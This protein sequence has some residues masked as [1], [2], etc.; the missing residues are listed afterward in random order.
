MP[1]LDFPNPLLI[2]VGP[3]A[4]GKTVFAV[5]IA[6]RL[7]GEIV[8]ADSR[9]F[10]RGMNIGTDK[11]LPE[12]RQSIPHH[13]IDIANP[14]E[15]WDLVRFQ[16]ASCQTI[17]AIENRGHLPILVGGTGQYVHAVI[18][19][20][21]A[22][23]Q[24]PNYTLRKAIEKWGQEIGAEQLHRRLGLLDV[25]SARIIEPHNLRRTVRALEVIFTTGRRFSDQR[26]KKDSPYSLCIL[27]LKRD[28]KELFQRIDARIDQMVENGLLDEVKGLLERGFSA[29]LP[30]LSAI[31]YR[32]MASVIEGRMTLEEAVTQMKRLTHRFVRRQANWFKENDPDIH[33]IDA[34]NN[35]VERAIEIIQNRDN[36]LIKLLK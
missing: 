9:L 23:A 19:G 29:D 25:D 8:S 27:G 1:Y 14:D 32:E 28:R 13:L 12:M 35:P 5:E 7:D 18:H 6:R 4:A 20:W 33:W 26:S 21:Q 22:P 34:E 24:Q 3:T 30:A 31:G 15:T 10:Y 36:W 16:A 2:V 11:P 17:A